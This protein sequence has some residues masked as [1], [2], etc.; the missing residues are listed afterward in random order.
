MLNSKAINDLNIRPENLHVVRHEGVIVNAIRSRAFLFGDTDMSRFKRSTPSL[1]ACGCGEEVKKSGT[2]W[3]RFI[4]GHNSRGTHLSEEHKQKII[5]AL[6]GYK[7]SRQTRKN[8]SISGR[9]RRFSDEHKRRISNT[10]KGKLKTQ[11]HKEKLSI[12]QTGKKLSPE[13][14]NKMSLVKIGRKQTQESILK[15]AIGLF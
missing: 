3:N 13:T 1:C 14:R 11:A 4:K 9:G 12:A 7:H 2:S 5:V 6:T 10:L 15:S 8:M